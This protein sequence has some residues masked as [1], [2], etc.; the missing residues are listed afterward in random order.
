MLLPNELD[1]VQRAG[2]AALDLG[3]GLLPRGRVAAQRQDVLDA[4]FLGL[5]EVAAGYRSC[6][7]SLGCPKA[8][9]LASYEP[10]ATRAGPNHC[11]PLASLC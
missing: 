10:L 7:G 5:Q 1:K 4:G 9:R 3:E 11:Q 2:K 8:H 6:R